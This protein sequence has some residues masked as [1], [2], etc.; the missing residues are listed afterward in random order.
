[1]KDIL[2]GFYNLAIKDFRDRGHRIEKLADER[3]K[4]CHDCSIRLEKEPNFMNCPA[5]GCYIPAKVRSGSNCPH[6]FW[7]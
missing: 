4:I 1:M 7:P 3:L 2:V 6:N 5:C